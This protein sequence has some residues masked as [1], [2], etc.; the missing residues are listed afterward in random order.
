VTAEQWQSLVADFISKSI[1]SKVINDVGAKGIELPANIQAIDKLQSDL[2]EVIRGA[3]DDAIGDRLAVGGTLSQ[4][5]VQSLVED[6]YDRSFT[7]LEA[8]DEGVE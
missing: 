2:H 4:S 5:E 3:V 6:I 8:L 1:E 7:Y